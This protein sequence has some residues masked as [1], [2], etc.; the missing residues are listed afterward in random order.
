[1]LSLHLHPLL[2]Q[3]DHVMSVMISD[4]EQLAY[5]SYYQ[6]SRRVEWETMDVDYGILELFQLLPTVPHYPAIYFQ[7]RRS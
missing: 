7:A 1:M 4:I 5:P 3:L 6:P 2:Y